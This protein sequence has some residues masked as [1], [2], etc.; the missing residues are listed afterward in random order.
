METGKKV[1]IIREATGSKRIET[2]LVRIEEALKSRGFA[3]DCVT[4]EA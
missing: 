4:E 3:Y 1:R 2:G